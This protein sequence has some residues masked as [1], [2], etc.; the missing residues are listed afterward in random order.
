MSIFTV[1]V[2]M[3]VGSL[4]VLMDANTKAQNMQAVVS[5]VSF[6]LDSMTRE[7]RTGFF[8]ECDDGSS[9]DHTGSTV[10]SC[11]SGDN[12]FAFTEAGDSLTNAMGSN[13]IAYRLNASDKSIER[14]L[15][16]L[17]PW[18]KLTADP[19][20]IIDRLEFVV[21]DTDSLSTGDTKTPT[22]SIF[23]SGSAGNVTGADATFT[24]QTTVSQLTL[25]I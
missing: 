5:N 3:A 6:A 11:P 18:Q 17:G 13:R 12:G 14:K 9:L 8:Y 10:Q 22:V 2:S 4:I 20:V 25:D 7:I 24:M 16:T 23:I 19:D 21:T 15:G 1:V